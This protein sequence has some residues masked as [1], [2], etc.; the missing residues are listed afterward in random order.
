MGE[1][2]MAMM[3]TPVGA[4]EE[5]GLAAEVVAGKKMFFL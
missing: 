5:K 1:E 4:M 3:G 2:V